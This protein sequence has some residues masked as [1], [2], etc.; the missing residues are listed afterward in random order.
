MPPDALLHW[1]RGRVRDEAPAACQAQVQAGACAL[2]LA[3]GRGPLHR[4]PSPGPAGGRT[5]DT[6]GAAVACCCFVLCTCM[7]P[8]I[9]HHSS[10]ISHHHPRPWGWADGAPSVGAPLFAPPPPPTH[11]PWRG[12]AVIACSPSAALAH[13][14]MGLG[15][16]MGDVCWPARCLCCHC[17]T[18]SCSAAAEPPPQR[19]CPPA[20]PPEALPR[21]P[22]QLAYVGTNAQGNSAHLHGLPKPKGLTECAPPLGPSGAPPWPPG[23]TP[24]AGRSRGSS[25]CTAAG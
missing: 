5:A 11:T 10:L 17:R 7:G 3:A 21:V 25:A 12:R 1:Y 15:G 23:T 14:R 19:P 13:G 4:H 24:R 18:C 9:S 16:A 6:H 20:R 22:Q 2:T 8:L